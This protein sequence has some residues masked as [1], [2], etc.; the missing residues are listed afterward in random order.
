[1][2]NNLNI[3]SSVSTPTY[4][5]ENLREMET[6][7]LKKIDKFNTEYSNYKKYL[8]NTRHNI[9]GDTSQKFVNSNNTIITPVD[10]ESLSLN[11]PISL[12]PIY[13]D[14]VKHI[15]TFNEALQYVIKHAPP[16]APRNTKELQSDEKI[17]INM[18]TNL[19]IKLRELNE[20]ENSLSL[21]NK[22]SLDASILVNILWTTVVTSLI[23]YIVVHS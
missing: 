16:P 18:R 13:I 21:E 19:D 22:R 1:M 17:I 7:L 15:T 4:T 20:I 5:P 6:V 23:F 3:P 12:T 10:F 8:Y 11:T 9:K 14:L 2:N